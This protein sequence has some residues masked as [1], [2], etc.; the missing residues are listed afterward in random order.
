LVKWE[1]RGMDCLPDC[2][3]K[4]TFLWGERPVTTLP[5]K[6][7]LIANFLQLA[8]KS[9]SLT[10]F[11]KA[12]ETGVFTDPAGRTDDLEVVQLGL[13]SAALL[14][15]LSQICPRRLSVE[16]GFGMGSSANVI[17][18]TRSLSK[19]PFEHIIFDPWG[20]PDGRGQ[21]VQA[22]LKDIFGSQFKRVSKP[23]QIGLA[24]LLD[25]RGP[26]SVG[27]AFIDG[28]HRFED[29]MADF[30]LADLLCCD[31]GF[32]V[33]DDSWFPA[34]ETV[35][36]YVDTNRPDY[37]LTHLAVDNTS[38]IRRLGRD[39]RDWSAFTPFHVPA[40]LDWT[41]IPEDQRGRKAHV[42]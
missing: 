4:A 5:H 3:Y 41:P 21:V 26:E 29:V 32:I 39:R 19:A 8:R 28:G 16:V 33:F 1:A 24:Q 2:D 17:I 36:S 25:E 20:L 15:H 6:D 7:D 38:V 27:L 34:I 10:R 18:S 12:F 40:R 22:Y 37:A 30:L 9:E 35:L 23:S 14:A 42:I 31:G 11:V 13:G